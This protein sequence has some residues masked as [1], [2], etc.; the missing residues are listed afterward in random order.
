MC[1]K[2][3]I[4][5]R[6]AK[7]WKDIQFIFMCCEE[8]LLK[9]K[10]NTID[11]LRLTVMSLPFVYRLVQNSRKLQKKKH[12]VINRWSC[13]LRETNAEMYEITIWCNLFYFDRTRKKN[14]GIDSVF[15]MCAVYISNLLHTK[16]W[17]EKLY[18]FE[19][20]LNTRHNHLFNPSNYFSYFWLIV[21][22]NLFPYVGA[23]S[24]DI[25]AP[26]S[27]FHISDP[28]SSN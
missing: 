21:W 14:G 4:L 27:N 28:H 18:S 23:H 8:S 12:I 26:C 9:L 19:W 6:R 5:T 16:N 11:I 22:N 10:I 25:L 2:T 20:S 17:L 24:I 1:H 7:N 13:I 3:I 15:A